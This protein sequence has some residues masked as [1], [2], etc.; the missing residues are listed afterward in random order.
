MM[1]GTEVDNSPTEKLST[2]GFVSL[3]TLID[4]IN[5]AVLVKNEF[6]H[7]QKQKKKVHWK[8]RTIRILMQERKTMISQLNTRLQVLC[9]R[10]RF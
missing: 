5:P 1:Q 4:K 6:E 3:P 9:F 8:F 7:R 2:A 10:L